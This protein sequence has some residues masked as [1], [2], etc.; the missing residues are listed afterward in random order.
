M[1]FAANF[2]WIRFTKAA[3][4]FKHNVVLPA[5]RWFSQIRK[6]GKEL[7]KCKIL[8]KICLKPTYK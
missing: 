6:K 5:T 8:S 7:E 4:L 3:K 2:V 1:P